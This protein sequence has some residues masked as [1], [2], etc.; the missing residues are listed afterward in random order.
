MA[1]KHPQPKPRKLITVPALSEAENVPQR[2]I[3]DFIAKGALP[4]VK[5]PGST[6]IWVNQFDWDALVESSTG[7]EDAHA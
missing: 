3:Y 5:F 7:R 2:T 4:R 6:R 1:Q